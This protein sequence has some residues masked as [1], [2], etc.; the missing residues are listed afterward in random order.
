MTWEKVKLGDLAEIYSG[1]AF[2][3]SDMSSE[4]GVPLIKIGNIHDKEVSEYCDTYINKDLVSAKKYDKFK[5]LNDD[6]LIAMTG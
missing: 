4:N 5:L 1:Y 3:S 6:F 2:K